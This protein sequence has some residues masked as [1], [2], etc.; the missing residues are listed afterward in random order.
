MLTHNLNAYKPEQLDVRDV[1]VPAIELGAIKLFGR[2]HLPSAP[3]MNA[4][5]N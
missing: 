2:V 4:L 5:F 1:A 3:D